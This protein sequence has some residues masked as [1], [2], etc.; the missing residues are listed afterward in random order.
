VDLADAQYNALTVLIVTNV[1]RRVVGLGV[2]S[3]SDVLAL[4]S[5]QIKPAPQFNSLLDAGFI[6]ARAVRP[7]THA[8]PGRYRTT[9]ERRRHGLA[10]CRDAGA[11]NAP[12]TT[13]SWNA[14]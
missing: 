11:L 14:S 10:G 8:D 6:T 3:V 5:E 1:A 4:A 12:L 2:D 9:D 7:G 13:K